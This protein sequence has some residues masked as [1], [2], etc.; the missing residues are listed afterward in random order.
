MIFSSSQKLLFFRHWQQLL[1]RTDKHLSDFHKLTSSH[2]CHKREAR[3]WDR[4]IGYL[5]YPWFPKTSRSCGSNDFA[6]ATGS[7]NR[8][9]ADLYGK[10]GCLSG[11]VFYLCFMIDGRSEQL[12]SILFLPLYK[13]ISVFPQIQTLIVVVAVQLECHW[14]CT[15]EFTGL[16]PS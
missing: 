11:L 12:L 16:A 14:A 4:A 9:S 6:C 2:W 8:S 10:M 7:G 15:L 13:L 5:R 1:T 3:I